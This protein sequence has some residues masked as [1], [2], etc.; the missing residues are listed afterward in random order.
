MRLGEKMQ[1][2]EIRGE[3]KINQGEKD[4]KKIKGMRWKERR[5]IRRYEKQIDEHEIKLGIRWREKRQKKCGI[6]TFT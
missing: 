1:R 6:S 5:V 3:E 4:V 2:D